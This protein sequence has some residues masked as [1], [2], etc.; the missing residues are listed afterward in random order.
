MLARRNISI[1]LMVVEFALL[2]PT[3]I[4]AAIVLHALQNRRLWKAAST[5]A[6]VRCGRALGRDALSR[7]D[8]VW[9]EHVK[10]VTREQYAAKFRMIRT[11]HAVCP[12]CNSW[13]RF[14][15]KGRTFVT[16]EPLQSAVPA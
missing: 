3:L 16:V 11:V 2:F 8:K 4:P 12:D 5:F 14:D 10:D 9:S 7:A 13:Y 6:C 1:S 15:E